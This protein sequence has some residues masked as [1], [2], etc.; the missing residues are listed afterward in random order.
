VERK[1]SAKFGGNGGRGMN[2]GMNEYDQKNV[3]N[4]MSI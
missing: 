2:H 1:R 3:Q 4:L